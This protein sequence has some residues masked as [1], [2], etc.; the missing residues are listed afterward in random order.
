MKHQ[1]ENSS[2]KPSHSEPTLGIGATL[3]VAPAFRRMRKRAHSDT[4]QQP[5]PNWWRRFGLS[6][7]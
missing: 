4:D 6:R 5:S 7:N 3:F 1:S 2:T